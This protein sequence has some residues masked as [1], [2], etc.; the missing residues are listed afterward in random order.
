[1]ELRRESVNLVCLF[2]LGRALPFMLDSREFAAVRIL[3]LLNIDTVSPIQ[4]RHIL[5]RRGRFVLF[6]QLGLILSLFDFVESREDGGS[7]EERVGYVS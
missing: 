4:R 5:G 3:G 1:M 2:L 6:H 7:N